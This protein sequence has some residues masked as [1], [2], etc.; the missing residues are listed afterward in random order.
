MK[1]ICTEKTQ[2]LASRVAEKLGAPLGE[3]K[4]SRFP[5]GELYIRA[6]DLDGETVIV[7]SLPDAGSIIELLLLID[8]CEG[9]DVTLV[10]PYMGYA[11]QDKRF[12]TGEPISIRA[13]AKALSTGVNRII[14]VNIH[15]PEVLKYFGVR[16]ENISIAPAVGEY[17]ADSGIQNPLILAPDDGAWVFAKGVAS[18]NSW[19]CD[20]LDKTRISGEEV[21]IEPKHI[22]VEG[23]N[24]VIVDDI[25]STGG[26]LATAAMLL[27]SQ[28]A[29]SVSAAC[30]HGVFSGG[31]YTRLISAGISDIS[32][33]DTI[34]RGCSRI[35]AAPSIAEALRR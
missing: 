11:R 19:D 4:R 10:I 24:V 23:R 9:S 8:A 5:D 1:V 15:E 31:G 35:F 28:G 17:L 22:G 14:T 7:S 20:H 33:S 21:R 12:N 26:T 32:S 25:I 18:A 30:V 2:I 6:L 27:R 16:S 3:V 13:I 29:V 34:E